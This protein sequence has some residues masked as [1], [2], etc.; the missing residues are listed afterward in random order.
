MKTT[1]RIGILFR[2]LNHNYPEILLKYGLKNTGVYDVYDI[3]DESKFH[4]L[5]LEFPECIVKIY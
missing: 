1:I 4:L 3:I 5:M 2:A